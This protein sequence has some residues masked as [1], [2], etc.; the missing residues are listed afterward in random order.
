MHYWSQERPYVTTTETRI[1]KVLLADDHPIVMSGC[2]AALMDFGIET[3]GQARTPAEAVRMFAELA[4]DVLVLDVKFGVAQTGFDAA[5]EILNINP[6]AKIV[7][8]SQCDQDSVIKEAYKIGGHAYVTKVAD[9][10][11]LAA[12]IKQAS[13][14]ILYFS[15]AIAERLAKLSVRGDNSPQKVLDERELSVF[16][17]MAKGLTNHEIAAELRF[18]ARTISTVS[19]NIKDKLGIH[20]AAD[21]TLMAVRHA[22]IEV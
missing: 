21:I 4:P 7:F 16:R 11:A 14:G 19:Q 13:A 1:I 20:R 15:P 3:L 6:K 5:K 18:A 12:A 10:E 17:L 2:K 9:P 8:W 22:V